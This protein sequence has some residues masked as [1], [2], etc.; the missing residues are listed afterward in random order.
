MA[1]PGL[2]TRPILAC[3]GGG[4]R[5]SGASNPQVGLEQAGAL[6]VEPEHLALEHLGVNQGS[7]LDVLDD[8]GQ[9]RGIQQLAG[10]GNEV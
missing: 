1:S 6:R 8:L 7:A 9:A 10:L 2:G 4:G 3:G 5:S